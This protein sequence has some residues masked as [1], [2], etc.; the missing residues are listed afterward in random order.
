MNSYR[1]QLASSPNAKDF[2]AISGPDDLVRINSENADFL[3]SHTNL[4]LKAVPV[5]DG[6]GVYRD[7]R[8]RHRIPATTSDGLIQPP[9]GT[10][11]TTT[12]TG[13]SMS[14]SRS[15]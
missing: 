9:S 2:G 15:R 10:T 1:D 7:P 12:L 3:K 6:K 8:N 13:S 5:P 11:S 14:S 4:S